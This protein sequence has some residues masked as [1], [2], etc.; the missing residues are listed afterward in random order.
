M[1]LE[2]VIPERF[3]LSTP[4]LEGLCFYPAELRNRACVFQQDASPVL[5]RVMRL[6]ATHA[7]C[8]KHR[9]LYQEL[10]FSLFLDMPLSVLGQMLFSFGQ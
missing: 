4:I 1:I 7:F 6:I 8:D 2:L 9:L 10:L 5:F 3:E